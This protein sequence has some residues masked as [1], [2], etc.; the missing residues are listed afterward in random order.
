MGGCFSSSVAAEAGPQRL[1]AG[2][3]L[4]GGK[5]LIVKALGRGSWADV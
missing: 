5:F 3:L 4:Q 1:Q 2:H